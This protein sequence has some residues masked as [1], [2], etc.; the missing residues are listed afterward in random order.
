MNTRGKVNVRR[1]QAMMI[2][3]PTSLFSLPQQKQYEFSYRNVHICTHT[4]AVCVCHIY[5]IYKTRS[6]NIL[7]YA[8]P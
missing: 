1:T 7:A 6:K 2:C 5:L 3:L 4:H 8:F